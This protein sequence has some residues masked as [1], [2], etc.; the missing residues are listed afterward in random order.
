MGSASL[1]SVD[2]AALSSSLAS[3]H[4]SAPEFETPDGGGI[5]VAEFSRLLGV[6]DHHLLGVLDASELSFELSSSYPL[7][8]D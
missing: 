4:G 8:Q 1:L 3:R 7:L 6:L 5:H 2:L